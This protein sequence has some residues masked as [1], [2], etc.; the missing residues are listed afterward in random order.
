[1]TAMPLTVAAVPAVV[2]GE[3]WGDLVN[4]FTAL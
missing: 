1:M 2:P 4:P 3:G